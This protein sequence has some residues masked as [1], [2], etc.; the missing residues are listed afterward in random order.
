MTTVVNSMAKRVTQ[1]T[2]LYQ[3]LFNARHP[4]SL[5]VFRGRI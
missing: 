5:F 2:I 3:R 1:T 4:F